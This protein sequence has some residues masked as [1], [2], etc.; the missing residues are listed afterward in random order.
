MTNG[1]SNGGGTTGTQPSPGL[2]RRLG[3]LGLTATGICA[4][5]GAA[6]NIIPIML[7]RNVP[8]IGPHVLPSYLF[9]AIPALVAA[10]AYASLSSAMPR[11]GG[12]Y[13][14][15][16]RSLSPYWGFVASFSQWFGLSIAI[17][18]VSYVLIPFLRDIADAVGWA[19]TAAAL[20]TGPIRVGLALAFLWT[21][22]IVNLRGLGV[23]QVTLVPMMFLM[24]A[25]GSVV[26]V[27]GFLFDHGDFGAA[28]MATE[29]RAV[30]PE[31]A[32]PFRLG[33]FLAAAAL[34]FSSFIGFD[35]IAQAGG[36]AR[37]PGRNLPLATGL[38]VVTVG[39]FYLLFTAAIY[40]AVPWSFVAQEAQLRDLTA[41][42]LLGYL[43]PTGWTVAI[44]AG[45]AVALINDLPA[46]LLAV[47]RLMFAW[48]EDGIFPRAVASVNARWRTPHAALVAS[49]LMA[50]VGILGSHLAGDFFLGIDILV[51]AMLVNFLLMCL[52]LLNLARRNPERAARM[53]V[54]RARAG[55]L[56]VGTAGVILLT[57]FL[58]VHINKDLSADVSAWYF[59][60]T[61]VWIGV[62]AVASAIFFVRVGRM[63]RQG[64]DTGALFRE[65]PRG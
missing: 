43:L 19:G 28:L 8:G 4:M 61:W 24:F 30:P 1:N 56:V 64:A 62:M 57:V 36:E 46:M 18:V 42:G 34:L 59:H 52:S 41:P 20:D 40:H 17:G 23:Y 13:I 26:I 31:P 58:G 29:G 2:S 60:S 47:S 14:Y 33:T 16:S 54:L 6:I 25:L 51:T 32:A 15:V 5:L 48:G 27:A 7:Q 22:V 11:A 44:V 35:S 50:T 10:L 45:A 53:Q 12:S 38:A 21:F 65:L 49:G 3:L 55:Q 63:R 37:N 9:A 39:A